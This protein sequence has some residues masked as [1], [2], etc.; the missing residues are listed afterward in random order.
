MPHTI[1][2]FSQI[3][4]RPVYRPTHPSSMNMRMQHEM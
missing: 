2:L 1:Q 3:H 4:Q